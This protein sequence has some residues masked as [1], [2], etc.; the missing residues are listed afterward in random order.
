MPNGNDLA[1]ATLKKYWDGKIPINVAAIARQCNMNFQRLELEE[2]VRGKMEVTTSGATIFYDNR[3]SKQLN[4][5]IAA[6]LLGKYLMGS[7]T[8]DK[9]TAQNVSSSSKD[10]MDHQANDFALGLLIP[11]KTLTAYIFSHYVEDL[12][13]ASEIFLVPAAAM[14]K[15][16]ST[17][18]LNFS[19][20][21]TKPSDWE[22]DMLDL[23]GAINTNKKGF[24]K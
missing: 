14:N 6:H 21:R 9:I 7:K 4:R 18:K 15:V 1:E 13:Q 3:N 16:M 8:V 10:E 24:N 19:G 17:L 20:P 5:F 11:K 22:S 12:N 23:S 2:G